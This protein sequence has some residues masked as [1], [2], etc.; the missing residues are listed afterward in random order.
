MPKSPYDVRSLREL[1]ILESV[2][3]IAEYAG[4]LLG[5]AG[6]VGVPEVIDSM[7]P[8]MIIGGGTLYLS[9]RW[10]SVTSQ[11]RIDSRRF[12]TLEKRLK[13]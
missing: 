3:A 7:N 6:V 11:D 13:R 12:E 5:V 2:P 8:I 1:F 10:A 9:A 4:I